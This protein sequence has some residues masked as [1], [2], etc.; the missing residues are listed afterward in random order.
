VWLWKEWPGRWSDREAGIDLVAEAHDRTLWAIQAKAY[1]SKYSIK[2]T[3]VDSF[4]SESARAMFSFRLLIATTNRLGTLAANAI[5]AQEKPVGCVM[6]HDLDRAAVDWP[7][8]P[9]ELRPGRPPPKVPYL[10][11]QKAVEA[12]CH[13]FTS[14]D[15]GQLIMA[16]GTGKTLV[17]L[18]VAER[19]KSERT[20]VLLPSLSLLAQTIREWTANAA[21]P[22]AHLAVCSDETVTADDDELVEHTS[23]LGVPV[24]TD[25]QAIAAF[26]RRDESPRVV[27]ATYQSSP[28][29]AEAFALGAP[30]FD[31]AI[32]DEA[33]RCVGPTSGNFATILDDKAIH[34]GRRLF[35]TATP[36]YFTERLRRQGT[37]TD[38]ELASM[39][40]P[41]RFGPTFHR[42]SF[43]EAI[44]QKLLADYQVA[45]IGVDDATYRAWAKSGQLVTTDGKT[46]T[47]ARTLAGEIGLVK[48]MRD[49][50]LRR[51]ISFHSRVAA[52]RAFRGHFACGRVAGK[53]AA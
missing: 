17:G 23:D 35:M 52:A 2:K 50:G 11:N 7:E 47:D 14:R 3:D 13:G 30:P 19:L 10:H 26:L 43:G 39:D 41:E 25:A 38:F 22:F 51:V 9:D 36:R 33:H 34:A 37:A 45:I 24:T 42:L 27:F 44:R 16:C 20:L 18:W 5:N 4:L 53:R 21:H 8:H 48:A 40:D 46:I 49:W 6:L 32:A 29:L 28:R 1:D 12:V 15:R 31:L